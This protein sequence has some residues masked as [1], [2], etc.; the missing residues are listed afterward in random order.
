[1]TENCLCKELEGVVNKEC[2]NVPVVLGAR[3]SQSEGMQENKNS[4]YLLK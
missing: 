3:R 2:A 4:F 1:M